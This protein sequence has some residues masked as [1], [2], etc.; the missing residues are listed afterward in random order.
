MI[1]IETVSTQL[2]ERRKYKTPLLLSCLR[3]CFDPDPTNDVLKVTAKSAY[4]KARHNP[5]AAYFCNARKAI[6]TL[7]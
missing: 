3:F 6:Y 5:D 2:L 1:T 7:L 4:S